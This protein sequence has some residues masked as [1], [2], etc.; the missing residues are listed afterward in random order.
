MPITDKHL[1][2]SGARR[3]GDD[4]QDIVVLDLIVDW[5][6]HGDKY[7]WIK[8]EAGETG[9]LDD[10][11]AK[12]PDGRIIARQVK[13]STDPNAADDPWTWESLLEIGTS[14]GK[15]MKQSLLQKWAVSL[16][17][18]QAL[19]TVEEAS[20]LSNRIFSSDLQQALKDGSQIHFDLTK[21]SQQ[22]S[23]DIVKQ[24]GDLA[25]AQAFFDS[26]RFRFGEP[27]L[28][29]LRNGIRRRF[30]RIGGTETGWN[31]LN[32]ALSEWVYYR[33]EPAP[34]GEITLDNIKTAA[35]WDL[36]T[37]ALSTSPVSVRRFADIALIGRAAD[38]KWLE[39]STGD[40]LLIGVP[41]SGKTFLFQKYLQ[42]GGRYFC[43]ADDR[44][45]I[46]NALLAVKPTVVILDDAHI[47]PDLIPILM[48]LRTEIQIRFDILASAWPGEAD[49]I[50]V[51]LSIPTSQTHELELLTRDEI[52]AVVRAA[53][54]GGPDALIQEIVVQSEGK[55]GLAVTLAHLCLAGDVQDVAIGNALARSVQTTF[56]PTVGEIATAILAG[57]A[58]GGDSGM[59]MGAVAEVLEISQAELKRRVTLLA[60]G[61]VIT[62]VRDNRLSVRPPRL[63]Y[64]LV[65]DVFYS[66]AFALDIAPYVQ[67]APSRY[68]VAETLIAARGHGATVSDEDLWAYLESLNDVRLWRI[69]TSLGT[70]E[71]QAVI[72]LRPDLAVQVADPALSNAPEET[73]PLLFDAAVG[74]SRPLNSNP[75]HPL[76]QIEDWVEAVE[77]GQ[78]QRRIV[79]LQSV[80]KWAPGAENG[81]IT[82]RVVAYAFSPN[83]EEHRQSPGIGDVFTIR[84]GVLAPN[85]ICALG[86]LWNQAKEILRAKDQLHWDSL[87]SAAEDCAYPQRFG[88]DESHS[89]TYSAMRGLAIEICNGL[90]ELA[91]DQIGLIARIAQ[92]L[93]RLEAPELPE[94]DSEFRVLFPI[95]SSDEW[96]EAEAKQKADAASLSAEWKHWPAKEVAA[97]IAAHERAASVAGLTWP[98]R[99]TDVCRILA[100]A[101]EDPVD[102]A[103]A[104]D[105]AEAPGDCIAE[106][107]ERVVGNGSAKADEL[108]IYCINSER[109]KWLGLRMALA[110]QPTSKL[111]L[112]HIWPILAQYSELVRTMCLRNEISIELIGQLLVHDD[113]SV[114][115]TT[116]I[117]LWLAEPRASIPPEIEAQWNAVIQEAMPGARTDLFWISEILLSNPSLATIWL[118]KYLDTVDT[119]YIYRHDDTIGRVFQKL[120]PDDRKSLLSHLKP[121]RTTDQ[122]VQLIVG[123]DVQAL[124][125]LLTIETLKEWHLSP[126]ETSGN[127]SN[128]DFIRSMRSSDA[129]WSN[130]AIVALDAGHSVKDVYASMQP[131]TGSWIGND[132]VMWDTRA[133][134]F[135]VLQTHDDVRIQEIGNLGVTSMTKMRDRS[136]K[137]ERHR[138]VYGEPDGF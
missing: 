107:V 128:H 97:R 22:I 109:L 127:H 34:D 79:L 63:R 58:V 49:P 80:R 62:E 33:N 138:D 131:T 116:A 85:D 31:S 70:S 52:A 78:V 12:L 4:Y 121:D 64:A 5:L 47:K 71:A 112:N 113:Q 88:V 136:L 10:V 132:S 61:G 40:R 11:V 95:Q 30:E 1:S 46:R 20:V 13:Y 90:I 3:L 137:S 21:V 122:V 7:A 16:P 14:T 106:F 55:P 98:R 26:F 48:Q 44:T 76:R 87:I 19:G 133:K 67:I 99:T 50:R 60:A 124:E 57:F 103:Y 42:T 9:S 91:R 105:Q 93:E 25:T 89:E 32:A 59:S 37:S 129:S 111:I 92:I 86:E 43:V 65:R 74:D 8:A 15:R 114:R 82:S 66:G 53:G 108:V 102:W 2:P 68:H 23:A 104:L 126:L 18:V 83:V 84:R 27:S 45:N 73:L 110:M 28:D 120:T 6:E 72:R 51:A 77:P 38:A 119:L 81:E 134:E 41:G 69:Y 39:E 115:I 94:L 24:F 101:V 56:E 135:A 96:E 125:E 118:S 17:K 130:M 100:E 35:K 29:E 75:G 36:T 123:T 54:I 117:G